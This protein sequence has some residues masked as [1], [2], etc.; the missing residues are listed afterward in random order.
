MVGAENRAILAGFG[1]AKAAHDPRLT[2]KGAVVGALHYMSPEQV[3]SA[4]Q[5]DHRSDVYSLGA[6][7][8]EMVTGQRVFTGKSHFDIMVAHVNQAPPNPGSLAPDLP[9]AAAQVILKAVAK[10]LTQ[11]YPDANTMRLALVELTTGGSDAADAEPQTLRPLPTVE[12]RRSSSTVSAAAVSASPGAPASATAKT[13]D[14]KL[15]PAAVGVPSSTNGGPHASVEKNTSELPSEFNNSDRKA[16][17]V[18]VC[19]LF[20]LLTST[21]V[22]TRLN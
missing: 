4:D 14:V 8:F 11:R 13:V 22:M 9:A 21:M 19:T 10:D 3:K 12:R 2:Q 20:F 16:I 18:L 1:Q 15:P 7:L 5:V 6:L 17:V